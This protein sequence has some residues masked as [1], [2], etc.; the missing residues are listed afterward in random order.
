MRS[1][2][3]S[4]R[5]RDA[6]TNFVFFIHFSFSQFD[7]TRLRTRKKNENVLR[8]HAEACS[9]HQ[10]F[11]FSLFIL[12]H[13]TIQFI[14]RKIAHYCRRYL[15]EEDSRKQNL[16]TQTADLM[17]KTM[18]LPPLTATTEEQPAITNSPGP[19]TEQEPPE[20]AMFSSEERQEESS[21]QV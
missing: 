2:F 8:A 21:N 1:F 16:M 18:E 10:F 3:S 4:A 20:T 14:M 17:T 9:M 19:N 7:S 15:E 12:Y 6:R 11:V 13:F 5:A